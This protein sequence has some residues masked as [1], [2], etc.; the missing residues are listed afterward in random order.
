MNAGRLARALLPLLLASALT[1]CGLIYTH[2]TKPLDTNFTG[3][4]IEP[5]DGM[6]IHGRNSS[7][8]L[9]VESLQVE[10][11]DRGIGQLAKDFGLQKVYY[12]DIETLS[13]LSI[14]RQRWI[15]IYGE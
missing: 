6:S 5:L 1:G 9:T 8:H 12:A 14:W 13:V 3:Q 4:Q 7:K 11:G 15:H 10:W 2:V